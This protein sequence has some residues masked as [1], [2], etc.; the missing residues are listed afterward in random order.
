MAQQGMSAKVSSAHRF[1][2]HLRSEQMILFKS[3]LW[4]GQLLGGLGGLGGLGT[5]Q[6]LWGGLHGLDPGG[7]PGRVWPQA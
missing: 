3:T 2:K 5:W 7:G 4:P 1:G 6:S